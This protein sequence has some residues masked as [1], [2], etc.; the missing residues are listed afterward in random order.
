MSTIEW[1]SIVE[2][3]ERCL[4]GWLTKVMLHPRGWGATGVVAISPFSDL[5]VPPLSAQGANSS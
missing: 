5:F 3:V 2:K 4:E 1:Q